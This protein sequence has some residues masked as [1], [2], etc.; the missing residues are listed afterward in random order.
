MLVWK[1]ELSACL[2][3]NPQ[4]KKSYLL[5]WTQPAAASL[6]SVGTMQEYKGDY[7]SWPEGKSAAYTNAKA[8]F[9]LLNFNI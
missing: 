5:R 1:K 9:L 3:A 8:C 4:K 6:K 2:Q 7:F